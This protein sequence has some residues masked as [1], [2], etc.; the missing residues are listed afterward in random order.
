MTG[1]YVEVCPECCG[2]T[3]AWCIDPDCDGQ[4][5][6]APCEGCEASGRVVV[7]FSPGC[8]ERFPLPEAERVGGYCPACRL[9]LDV[10]DREAEERALKRAG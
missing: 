5:A 10:S 6:W 7:C 2:D 1:P 4:R 9:E 3:G 8:G